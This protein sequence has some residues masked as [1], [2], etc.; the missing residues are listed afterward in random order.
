MISRILRLKSRGHFHV[1]G[2]AADMPAQFVGVRSAHDTRTRNRIGILVAAFA[3]LFVVIGARLTQL[4]MMSPET[5]ASIM[6]RPTTIAS[7]P[8]LLDRNGELLATDVN[9]V[10]LFAEPNKVID[11]DEVVEELVKVIPDLDRKATYSR[12]VAKNSFQWLRRQLTPRQQSEILALGLPG[13]GFR[14]EKRRFY[15]A[16][17]VASHVVG[18]VNVDNLGLAGMERYLDNQGLAALREL[19][20]AAEGKLEPVRLSIDLRVQTIVRDVIYRAMVD[21]KAAAAGAVVLDVETGEILAMASVPDY[22][23]NMPSRLT[24]DGQVDREYEKGWFNRMSNATYEMGSTFKSFTLAMGLEANKITLDTVIDASKPIRM[25]G[26]TIRDFKGKYRPLSIREV[27]QYSSNIAT[28]SVADMVGIEAHQAFLTRLGLLS[29]L[30][31]ELPE[32]AT[33]TQPRV[34]KKINATTISY[35]HGVSTTPLQTAVAGASLINGGFLVPTTFLPR[36]REEAARLSKKV[37]K[38]ET[39][40]D[41]RELFVWNG[42]FGSGRSA[43]VAGFEVGGKTGTADKVVN[44]SYNSGL[45]FNAFLAGF[46]M[47]KPRY[48]VLAVID[49]PRTGLNGGVTAGSTAAP[50]VRE[51]IARSGALLGVKPEFSRD[52]TLMVNY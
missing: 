40:K 12:L 28:A 30:Q 6:M 36:S 31:T 50:M 29:K 1:H 25:G 45:N 14:P 18:H 34:W 49:G 10:S 39:S 32:I 4:G 19:G 52:G 7:R 13:L 46:P 51:I 15:P 38:D 41:M 20:L 47:S 11:P 44:G 8:D 37:I 22:D 5:T 42:L 23:P 35:G 33:P 43:Q 3:F 2:Q 27:F 48:I 24:E 17:P 9:M 26:F 16:G 21:Y